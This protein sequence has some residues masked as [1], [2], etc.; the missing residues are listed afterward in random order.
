MPSS[1]DTARAPIDARS[2]HGWSPMAYL[3]IPAG[4]IGTL[5]GFACFHRMTNRQFQ[6]AVNVLFVVS[7]VVLL[8]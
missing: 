6:F 8:V 4:L 7:G 2:R 3:Y 5:V 1:G